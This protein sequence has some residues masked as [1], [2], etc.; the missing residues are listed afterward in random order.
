MLTYITIVFIYYHIGRE[1]GH[2]RSQVD[3]HET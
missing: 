3:R 1:L 2:M